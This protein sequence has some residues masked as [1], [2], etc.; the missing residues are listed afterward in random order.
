MDESQERCAKKLNEIMY[1][2]LF[3]LCE[4]LEQIY[5]ERNQIS[6]CLEQM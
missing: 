5:Y 6:G 2:I 3:H 4:I 1:T